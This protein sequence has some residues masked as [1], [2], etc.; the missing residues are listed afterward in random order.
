MIPFK[1]SYMLGPLR[2]SPH[3]QAPLF[4]SLETATSQLPEILSLVSSMDSGTPSAAAYDVIRQLGFVSLYFFINSILRPAGPYDA[5]NDTLALDQCNFRQSDDCLAPGSKAAAFMPRGF[6]KTRVNTTGGD[7]WECLRDPD[8]TICVANAVYEK[9][10]EFMHQIER[11]FDANPQMKL[12]YPEYVPGKGRGQF[13]DKFMILPNRTITATEPTV[14][15]LG[16]T[17]GAEGGHYDLLSFDDLVGLDSVD[18]QHQSSANMETAR[19]WF[20]TNQRAL[21]KT[22]ASRLVLAATRYA[23]DDCYEKIYAS[24]R[25]L[26]GWMHGDIQPVPSGEWNIYYRLIEED[27]VF[28][29][30]DVLSR[31]ELAVLMKEDPWS[32]MVNYYNSPMKAGLA[33]FSDATINECKLV[34]D[35]Q[36]GE[37]W[38]ER[39]NT[40]YTV[41]PEPAVRLGSCD[42][43]MTTDLAATDRGINSKTCRSSIAVWARDSRG[44]SYR[45]WSRVGF[46]SIFQS[47]DYMFEG[48]QLFAGVCRGV[49]VEANAFQKIIEPIVRREEVLRGIYINPTPVLASGDKKARIRSAWG[50]ALMRGQVWATADAAKPLYE[51][52]RVF[53][54]SDSKLDCLDESE[55]ALTYLV[56]PMSTDERMAIEDRDRDFEFAAG[57]N[58]VGY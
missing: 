10:F 31:D 36:A 49:L 4:E 44:N 19:K 38:I 12:F 5:L 2:I 34:W 35:K 15:C 24:C 32:A 53:P 28:I 51:E 25:K 30:P 43:L 41:D 39:C 11:N 45:I 58:A 57:M 3:P 50:V 27:G 48:S 6:S 33:E 21:R 14:R 37:Y 52:L 18:S 56:T 42:V 13:T 29:R 17:G 1:P 16:V 26:T 54:M 9:A 8:I 23:I 20:S 55:K 40:N 46:F 47:I 22:S 7:T